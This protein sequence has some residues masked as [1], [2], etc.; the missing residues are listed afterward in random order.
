MPPA[1]RMPK[2]EWKYAAP[3]GSMMATAWPA[4]TPCFLQPCGNARRPAPQVAVGDLLLGFRGD[5]DDLLAPGMPLHVPLE[6]LLQGL[7]LL[8]FSQDPLRGRGPG[9][10]RC[11]RRH[12]PRRGGDSRQK[13]AWRLDVREGL[14]GQ[15]NAEGALDAQQEFDTRQAVQA[16]VALERTVEPHGGA[17]DPLA[18]QV[19]AGLAHDV[20][21]DPLGVRRAVHRVSFLAIH[22]SVLRARSAH[23]GW[24]RE[25]R[26]SLPQARARRIG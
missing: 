7:R 1:R 25:E 23:A 12:G 10:K 21:K 9:E 3:V 13:V 26:I 8:G 6:H 14:F 11:A 4:S 20:E 2:N 18:M 16:E 17:V 5:D 19:P 15:V 22:R 24:R